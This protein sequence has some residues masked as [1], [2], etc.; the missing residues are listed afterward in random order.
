MRDIVICIQ[1]HEIYYVVF[2]EVSA[3]LIYILH[4]LFV[5]EEADG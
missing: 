1:L 5:E 3:D 4:N 2:C